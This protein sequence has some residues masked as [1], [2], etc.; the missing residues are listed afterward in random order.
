M[1]SPDDQILRT[2]LPAEQE[3]LC[4][5]WAFLHGLASGGINPETP[6][7]Q[8]F[9]EVDLYQKEPRNI[10][11]FLWRQFQEKLKR[12]SAVELGLKQATHERKRSSQPQLNR[13]DLCSPHP[14]DD[15]RKIS[16]SAFQNEAA[17]LRVATGTR[18][19]REWLSSLDI[20][21]WDFA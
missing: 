8:H 19:Y 4:R 21:P 2:F 5:Y 12:K 16:A 15:V 6:A 14:P 7:Q 11:E 20:P 3:I 13:G 1:T 18:A 9:I 17:V 10:F